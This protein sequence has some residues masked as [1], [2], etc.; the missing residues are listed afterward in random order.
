MSRGKKKR[1]NPRKRLDFE[2][3][4]IIEDRLNHGKSLSDL[5]EELERSIS[6]IGREVK[7]HSS[8]SKSMKND[9]A[10]K[11][12]CKRHHMCGNPTCSHLC[13]HCFKKIPCKK[14][15]QD[16]RSESCAK[17]KRPPYVCNGCKSARFCSYE[18]NFYRARNAENETITVRHE[19][20]AG[21]DLTLEQLCAIDRMVSPMLQNGCSVYHVVQTLGDNLPVSE[22]TLRR[23]IDKGELTARNID[24]R[25]KVKLRPRK[26]RLMKNEQGLTIRKIGRTWKDYLAYMKEHD[27]VCTVQMDC[28]EGSKTSK[29]VLLT[30]HWTDIGFQ[31]ARLMPS[32]TADNVVGT[33]DA[34]E[35]VVGTEMFLQLFPVILTDNGAEF[36]DI[37]GIERSWFDGSIQR[38]KVFF[39]EP[40]RADEKG[41]CENNHKYIRYIIP[42]GTD[43]DQFCQEEIDLCMSHVNSYRRKKILGTS[44]ISIAK[45]IF[46]ERFLNALGMVEI[47]SEEVILRPS[48]LSLVKNEDSK[49][50]KMR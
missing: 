42:K 4:V 39:C 28:V 41:G 32:Q 6:T 10:L 9:C 13:A 36:T 45:T 2:E 31:I 1:L 16:Y 3:R 18:Q 49:Y 47:P 44:P 21:F 7:A 43:L 5:A 23:L 29:Q 15:C 35:S 50:V 22:S 8:L 27:D 37:E 48:L 26:R 30:L 40:N 20:N 34:I 46:P 25:S 11:N 33:L 17:L 12:N 24:L 14:S 38:T 19:S